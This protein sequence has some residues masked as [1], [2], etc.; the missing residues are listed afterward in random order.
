MHS[1]GTHL[2][3]ILTIAKD[4]LQKKNDDC[5]S[6]HENA[7]AY[8]LTSLNSFLCLKASAF[9][10][11]VFSEKLSMNTYMKDIIISNISYMKIYTL[12]I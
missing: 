8:L 11:I 6:L 7:K 2:L 10:K 3:H 9:A 4:Y 1:A 5:K 12:S